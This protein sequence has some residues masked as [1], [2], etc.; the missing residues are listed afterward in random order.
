MLRGIL[1]GLLLFVLL[2]TLAGVGSAAALY[3]F[4]SGGG[5]FL[6][7]VVGLDVLRALELLGEKGIPMR[8]AERVFSDAVAMNHVVRQHPPGGRRIREERIVSLTLSKGSRNVA[9]PKVLGEHLS[10]A[11][12]LIRLRGLRVRRLVE[13]LFDAAGSIDQ[14]MDIWPKE[15]EKVRRGEGVVLIVSQ[16]ARERAY[17]MPSLIGAPVNKALDR[18][19][20]LSLAVGR[21]SLC[22]SPGLPAR[23]CCLANPPARAACPGGSSRSCGC[24]RVERD[25]MA[26]NFIVLRY[27][28]PHGRPRRKLRVELE[29]NGE[30]REE[31]SRDVRAGEE[32]HLLVRVKGRTKA[33]IFLDGRLVEE[34]AH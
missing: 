4:R 23:F 9:V 27:R 28:V 7:Q 12:T 30:T 24:G 34:Q 8:V 11:E 1:K 25:Q 29:S 2:V 18:V 20:A 17:V 32:I 16:G 22:G 3:F 13:R 14:V 5:V 21:V 6:P 26:G 10:R 15:G 33:R 31:L 19:R